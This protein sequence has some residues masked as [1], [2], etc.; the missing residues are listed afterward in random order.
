MAKRPTHYR[1]VEDFVF[2]G[3]VINGLK[4]RPDGRFYAAAK[5]TKTF[6]KQSRE[7]VTKFLLWQVKG[8][9]EE[10]PTPGF[11]FWRQAFRNLIVNHPTLAG[12]VFGFGRLKVRK[13]YDGT[14]FTNFDLTRMMIPSTSEELL[15]LLWS[16]EKPKGLDLP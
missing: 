8:M 9:N 14:I 10:Q 2:S 16:G 5:P 13:S 4:R 12:E 3:H 11:A 7:A 15:E 1:R 6:G